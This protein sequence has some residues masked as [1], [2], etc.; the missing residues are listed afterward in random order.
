MVSISICFSQE[1]KT[2]TLPESIV[3]GGFVGAAEVAMPGQVLSYAMNKTIAKESFVLAQSYKGFCMNAGAQMPIMAIENGIK[4]KGLEMLQ[5]T[6]ESALSEMQ[7][8]GISFAAGVGGAV[9]ENP[10]NAIQL[11]Q[12]HKNNAGISVWQASNKLGLKGC[13]RGFVPGAILKEGPFVV[14][15]QV[16]GS[17]GEIIAKEYVDHDMAAKAIGGIGA[18]V[19]TAVVTQPGAVMRNT[20]QLDKTHASTWKTAHKILN[21]QGFKGFFAGLH[22]RGARIA[23]AIPLFIIYSEALEKVVKNKL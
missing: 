5:K 22:H 4:T 12:Q 2:L 9:V 3:V 7:K 15:Y 16:L 14:G 20:M 13:C 23:V 1:K 19:I 6:Q 21:E 11:Y 10:S 8:T 18:G 17:K